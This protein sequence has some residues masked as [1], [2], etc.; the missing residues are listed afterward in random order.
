ML[1]VNDMV[2][3]SAFHGFTKL[4]GAPLERSFGARFVVKRLVPAL[5]EDFWAA[6]GADPPSGLW[7]GPVWSKK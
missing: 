4:H 6:T 3:V 7:D 5:A 1:L 2:N